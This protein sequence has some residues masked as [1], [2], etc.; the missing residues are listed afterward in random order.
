MIKGIFMV[1]EA[2]SPGGVQPVTES[3]APAADSDLA[4]QLRQT[5]FSLP[6]A[7]VIALAAL[8]VLLAVAVVFLLVKNSRLRKKL[9]MGTQAGATGAE[10]IRVS[11]FMPGGI[12]QI[13]IGKLHAQGA[14]EYQ[15]DCFAVSDAA[16][17]RSHGLLAIV[18]DGM[19]GLE[20]GDKVSIATVETILGAFPYL[21]QESPDR[22]LLTLA[23]QAVQQVNKL[24]GPEGYRKSGST[25]VMGL[26]K[27]DRFSFLTMGDSHIY[28]LRDGALMLLNREHIFRNELVLRA[29]NGEISMQEAYADERGDGLVSFIGMGPIKYIDMP[30]EPVAVRPGDKFILMSDGIYN[31]L[32]PDELCAALAGEAEEAVQRLNELIASKGY[33]NQDNYTG[34]ILQ[35]EGGGP[36]PTAEDQPE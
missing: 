36:A 2:A 31:A 10:P 20:D 16:L 6:P 18:A 11:G 19:G 23:Q 27:N 17:I 5:L 28:L 24:L 33:F 21:R 1:L 25:L 9:R 32:E 7:L 30:A 13:K 26:L 14:R 4:E 3:A 34:I 29:V 8:L 22:Q 15:Q 35:C 12:T